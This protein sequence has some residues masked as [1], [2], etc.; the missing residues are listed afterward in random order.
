MLPKILRTNLNNVF[1]HDGD[2]PWGGAPSLGYIII[3]TQQGD[4]YEEN[5]GNVDETLM[6]EATHA[7]L[8]V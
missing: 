7:V 8:D 3:H 4:E 5:W 1:I 2:Y 6:H